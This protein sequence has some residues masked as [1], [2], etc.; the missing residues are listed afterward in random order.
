M[1]PITIPAHIENGALTLDAPLP[2]NAVSVEVRVRLASD[3]PRRSVADYLERMPV[4]TRTEEEI[5]QQLREE[6]AS[7]P[8]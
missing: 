2:P 7:W 3:A 5:A 8:E 1:D 4:G 6:R